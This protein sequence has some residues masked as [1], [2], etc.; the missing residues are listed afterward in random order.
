[1]RRNQPHRWIPCVAVAAAAA[2]LA[3][4]ATEPDTTE[5]PAACAVTFVVPGEGAI[6]ADTVRARVRCG[7]EGCRPARVRFEDSAGRRLGPDMRTPPWTCSWLP[8]V[9]GIEGHPDPG[10]L[11]I[12]ARA[13][14]PDSSV[15]GSARV[16]CLW[17]ANSPPDIERPSSRPAIERL[18]AESLRV[19]A[20]DPEDGVLRGTAVSWRSDLQGLLGTGAVIPATSLVPGTHRI[21]VRATDRWQRAATLA[22]AIEAF[23]FDGGRSAAG[24]LEDLRRALLLDRRE[25]HAGTLA[26]EYRFV[27]CPGDRAADPATPV[28]WSRAEECAFAERAAG[29]IRSLEWIV[30]AIRG[31]A[32]PPAEGAVAEL[33]DLRMQV[34]AYGLDASTGSVRGGRARVMLVRE[35]DPPRWQVSSWV[36]LGAAGDWT[37]GRLRRAIARADSIGPV[38]S[39]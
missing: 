18:P 14:G 38:V 24:T 11:E 39:R 21:E 31:I 22:F 8:Q 37:Y 20:I 30:A 26:L 34:D 7:G 19:A 12:R 15:V 23:S 13:Y 9:A 17:S 1:M 3:G 35:G 32:S 16:R 36:D 29:R 25:R 5:A 4:C 27:F 10:S 33:R 6:T 2:V 28:A